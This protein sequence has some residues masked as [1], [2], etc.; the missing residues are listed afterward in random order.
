MKGLW[1]LSL[2]GLGQSVIGSRYQIVGLN[3]RIVG[4][5]IMWARVVC[6]QFWVLAGTCFRCLLLFCGVFVSF[7]L[8]RIKVGA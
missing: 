4:F 7:S 8:C 2:C 5:V 3:E 6:D 1:A